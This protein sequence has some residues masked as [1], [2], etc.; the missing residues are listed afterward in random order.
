MTKDSTMIQR[1][2]FLYFWGFIS[3]IPT[4][5][6]FEGEDESF[7]KECFLME[8][9]HEKVQKYVDNYKHI[10]VS[11]MYR[12][13]VPA[14][15]KMAQGLLESGIGESELALKANNHFGIKCGGDWTGATYYVW[16]DEPVKSCF[17]VYPSVHDC[18]I[19]HTDFLTNPVKEFRYGFLFKLDKTDY[20]AWAKGLQTAGYATSKTYAEKL[21]ALIEKYELYKLDHLKL[22][23]TKVSDEEMNLVFGQPKQEP[24]P[25]PEPKTVDTTI[26][27]NAV[28]VL[29]PDPF[30]LSEDIEVEPQSISQDVFTINGLKAVLI[31]QHDNIDSL[32][33]RYR[34]PVNKLIKYNELTYQ[35]LKIGHYIFLQ[36]KNAKHVGS[37]TSHTARSNET[38]YDISQ[39][40]GIQLKTLLKL[41][42]VFEKRQPKEKEAV[43]LK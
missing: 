28:L 23:S 13:G 16:D 38:L 14:S 34:I 12:K 33:R 43:R 7:D 27:I 31:Q 2:F 35:S 42:K 4:V 17:R 11:E 19:A 26:H 20:K 18:Y 3:L 24:T 9:G 8:F 21:I 29:V 41:N 37:N 5:Q 40:Y 39:R 32:A 22:E 6:A 36:K 25:I 30:H 1:F 10:A 15:I